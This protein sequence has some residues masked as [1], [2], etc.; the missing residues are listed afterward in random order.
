[1]LFHTHREQFPNLGH[2]HVSFVAQA[3]LHK[4]SQLG[5]AGH[6]RNYKLDVSVSEPASDIT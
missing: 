1:M 3:E 5:V 6:K 4:C 2:L